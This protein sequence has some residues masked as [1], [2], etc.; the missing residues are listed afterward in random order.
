MRRQSVRL[1]LGIFVFLAAAPCEISGLS[2]QQSRAARPERAVA[3]ARPFAPA[4]LLRV[5]R[6]SG[7]E[8]RH[9]E[10]D[11][12]ERYHLD[13]TG[14]AP[15]LWQ[16]IEPSLNVKQAPDSLLRAVRLYGLLDDDD[17]TR[18]LF[19]LLTAPDPRVVLLAIDILATQRPAAAL[20]RLIAL[21]KHPAYSTHYGL[22]HA[23]VSAVAKFDDPASVEFL[24]AA[25]ASLDGQLKYVAARQL[26]R[27]TGQH[28]GSK[29]DEWRQWWELNR[30]G[31]RVAG[32]SAVPGS[33]LPV[34]VTKPLADSIPWA[35]DVPQFFGTPIFAKRVVFV[36]DK[37]KSMLSS[38]AGVTRLD[39]AEKQLEAAIRGLPDDA[40]FE[41][42]AYND[43]EQ[44]YRGQLAPATPGEKSGAAQFLY[45][46]VAEGQ[47]DI[48]DTLSDALQVDPNLEA[49]LFL[50]DG[51]PNVGTIVDRATIIQ[52]ITQQ[53]AARRI[54]INTIGIDARGPSEDFLKQLAAD[55][56]GE[57]RSSR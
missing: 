33:F 48:Y 26:A 52:R 38:V 21:Q 39:D 47:T 1:I 57:F 29:S 3:K 40:W 23:V 35:Y 10:L 31:F 42:I 7:E 5:F 16:A 8:V 36:I 11:N 28:F 53:N 37:S 27:L 44:V 43:S 51:D 34:A 55:N 9:K 14:V 22:R 30:T 45:S 6:G 20:E 17:G 49:I 56:F 13:E 12:I 2:A 4:R 19:S 50:S 15:A 54:S 46:L 25:V 18:R 41:I 24:I 32:T